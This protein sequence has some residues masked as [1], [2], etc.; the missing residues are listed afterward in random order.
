M[1]IKEFLKRF[2]QVHQKEKQIFNVVLVFCILITLA[3]L[4]YRYNAYWQIKNETQNT[5]RFIELKQALTKAS[6][7]EDS[8]PKVTSAKRLV[9]DFNTA[10]K[11]QMMEVN[12]PLWQQDLI[13][14]FRNSGGVFPD[15]TTLSAKQQAA[16][17]YS[18]AKQK[19]YTKSKTLEKKSRDYKRQTVQLNSAD[20]SSLKL[21]YGIGT[22][23]SS[24]IVKYRKKLGGFTSISQLLEVYG[25]SD[26]VFYWNKGLIQVD[27]TAITQIN[28]NIADRKSLAAHPYISWQ[29]ATAIENYRAQHGF[30]QYSDDLLNIVLIDTSLY[31]KIKPYITIK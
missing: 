19:K 6:L 30:Y 26:S 10:S 12:I 31:K 29:L 17:V 8:L 20:T 21:L 23:L 11:Q 28:I 25:V 2:S 16:I 14:S 9:L 18:Y 27:S 4:V 1:R 7:D 13:I 24:R 15:T 5:D 3:N 22:T